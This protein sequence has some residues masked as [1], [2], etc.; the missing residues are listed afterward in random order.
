[1]KQK[2]RIGIKQIILLS[3]LAA[4]LGGLIFGNAM[5]YV[6][7]TEITT[8]LSPAEEIVDTEKV[9][10]ANALGDEVVRQ[11]A[12]EGVT[13]M[14]N[15]GALP[16]NKAA[17]NK[18]NLF[19]VG[20]TDR[21]GDGTAENQGGFFFT[22]TGSGASGIRQGKKV[23][24]Q[25]GMEN[26]GLEVNAELLKAYS[27]N[28]ANFEA[29]WY[30]TTQTV[31]N[32]AKNFSDIAIVTISRM[33]GENQ[34]AEEWTTDTTSPKSIKC[35]WF[36]TEE[37]GRVPLQLSLK[38]EAMLD[39]VCGNFRT[40]IVLI[41]SGNTM[42]LGYMER[43]EVD[44]LLYVSHPGQSGCDSIGK[45]LT[46][47]YNPSGHL[48]DTFVYDSQKDPTWANV[49]YANK[50]GKQIAYAEDI[51]VGYKYYETADKEG[52]FDGV[53]NGYGNGYDGMVQYPFGHGLSYTTFAWNVK[54]IVCK[55]E[56]APDPATGEAT[57]SI[58]HA[59]S[60]YTFTDKD[61]T[62]EITVEVTNTGSRAGKEV[63]QVYYTAPYTKG[64]IEK[65]YV[66]LVA[67]AK[68]EE[69][70]PGATDEVTVSFDIYDMASYDCYD[71]NGNGF[72]GWELDPG[73]YHVRLMNN[74]HERN[75]CDG[76]DIVFN[77]SNEGTAA[78]PFGYVYLFDPDNTSG[79]VVNRFTGDD[80]EAGVPVDGNTNGEP[81]AYMSRANFAGTFPRTAA[82]NRTSGADIAKNK[83]YYTDWDTDTSLVAPRLNNGQSHLYL[84]TKEDG[85]QATLADLE[86]TSGATIVPNEELI[87][88]LGADYES[89]KWDELLSQLSIDDIDYFIATAGYGTQPL[90]SI[91]VPAL[92]VHDGPSGFNRGM[93]QFGSA[94]IYTNFPVENMVAMT[95]NVDL[96]R[97]QGAAIGVEAQ[98]TGEAGIY[99]PTVNLHRSP[100]N[101]RNFEAYSEDG[102]LS[103]YM[104]AKFIYGARTHGAQ[105]SLKHFV[106]SEPGQNPTDLNTW[107]TEQ[108][109]RE[110]YLK[111]FEIAVKDGGANFV[112]SAFN[113]VGGV[114]C[115]YSYELLNGVL[116]QEWG[117]KG[118]V[119][120][121]YGVGTPKN[122][123]RS[124]NDLRLIP[125][126]TERAGLKADNAADVYCGVT[127]VK[128]SLYTHCNV[129]YTTKTYNP[130]TEFAI[131]HRT[132]P[133][134][135]WIPLLIGVDV[136]FVGL[137]G[138]S[139]Y[140]VVV[141]RKKKV[142]KTEEEWSE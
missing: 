10:E 40:V 21:S 90:E 131:V 109:L 46:G 120:T 11:I 2:I 49:I 14:K 117:F 16:L 111:A 43:E 59:E 128:N 136:L 23:T 25:Q 13:L 4:L 118:S 56:G 37:D 7:A 52:Y 64:K 98:A 1:M 12:K 92:L 19:G 94:N 93:T 22:G 107:L 24:L 91:G 34:G 15:N 80:A 99:A 95:W 28:K 45:I 130:E 75:A 32:N 74:A 119:V 77:V 58:V 38:E 140:F 101:T 138:L 60:G 84:Y 8:H 125:N 115:A 55:T 5:C 54:D 42:E 68:T 18:V 47:E 108:N 132:Q 127:A 41:N 103:G 31:L 85:S 137:I 9:E 141:P 63:V 142:K 97:Q 61:T 73:E 48:V 86:R 82:P 20:S 71:K 29:S 44:A 26:A 112:M 110:N 89:E 135:W 30:S 134:V 123:I 102:V 76:S 50:N 33:T 105:T 83:T 36:D 113:N 116:R 39:Y 81:I 133:F 53:E 124:G 126:V 70:A 72:T 88:E 139:A 78:E 62:V 114:K 35:Q 27:D 87:M 122:L 96:A 17:N 66:N 79:I 3:L 121:D 67:F 65:S 6:H 104:A 57:E 106:L 100:Y 69:I 129:Y 51:Y